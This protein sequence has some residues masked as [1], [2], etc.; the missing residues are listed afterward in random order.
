MTTF[1]SIPSIKII[2]GREIKTSDL[3]VT[4]NEH[5]TTNGESV[6]VCRDVNECRISLDHTTT[7]H[8]TIKAMTNVIVSTSTLID[9]IYGEVEMNFGSC[10]EFRYII[11]KW[12]IMS[13]DGLKSS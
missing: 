10:V 8:V 11:D 1:K 5:Y 9:D 3:V 4:N 12:Y 7:D 2:A 13:S 6:I